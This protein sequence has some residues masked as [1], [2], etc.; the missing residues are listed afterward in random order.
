MRWA[1][2]AY[3]R[4]MEA[5]RNRPDPV[6]QKEWE[7]TQRRKDVNASIRRRLPKVI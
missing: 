7:E 6:T 5:Q 1:Q 3:D 4:L 2:E